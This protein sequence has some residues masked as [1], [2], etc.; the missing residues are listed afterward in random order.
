MPEALDF[1]RG[2]NLNGSD[3]TFIGRECGIADLGPGCPEMVAWAA[4]RLA[5]DTV[6]RSSMQLRAFS[7]IITALKPAP[8]PRVVITLST[9]VAAWA[10]GDVI[11]LDQVG[12]AAAEA[13]VQFYA[14][15]EVAD[16]ADVTAVDYRQMRARTHENRFLTSGVQIVATAAGGEAFKVV[17]QADR[18]FKRIISETSGTYRLGVEA[19]IAMTKSRLLDVK[20][21]VRRPGVT[22]RANR[23]AL[24]PSA[25]A[26][27]TRD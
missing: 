22:V 12:R 3:E 4:R 20:V 13:G 23:H 15:T 21:S 17:G 7:A 10:E 18:F 5:R 24:A 27:P 8:A 6:H 16:G 19:A 11:G 2:T 1:E 14:L 26:E 9:G 25:N